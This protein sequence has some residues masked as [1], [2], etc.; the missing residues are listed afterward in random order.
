MFVQWFG[1][2]KNNKILSMFVLFP[3]FL[4]ILKFWLFFSKVGSKP[5]TGKQDVFSQLFKGT[6]IK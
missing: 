6:T 2:A 1:L 3:G 5:Y 4:A